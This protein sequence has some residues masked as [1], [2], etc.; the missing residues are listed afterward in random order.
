MTPAKLY[1]LR[2]KLISMPSGSKRDALAKL[3]SNHTKIT[4]KKHNIQIRNYNGQRYAFPAV[5]PE[6]LGSVS[7]RL[8][9]ISCGNYNPVYCRYNLKTYLVQSEAGD[10]SDSFRA[11]A[12][13]LDT[14]FFDISKPCEFNI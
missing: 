12:S 14:L 3:I 2:I 7:R 10:I 6:I 9:S 11:D 13:Y 8:Y 4:M 1:A 5:A